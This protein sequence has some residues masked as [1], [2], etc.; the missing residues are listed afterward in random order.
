MGVFETAAGER[1]R[2]QA[3]GYRLKLPDGIGQEC[4]ASSQG[5]SREEE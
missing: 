5:R 3:N 2:R 1:E 4:L